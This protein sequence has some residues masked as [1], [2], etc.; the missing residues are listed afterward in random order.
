MSLRIVFMGTPDYGV[1]SLEALLQ[2]G[3]DVVGVF[4]QP[5][6]PSGRGKKITCCPVKQYAGCRDIPVFQPVKTRV[7]GVEPLRALA[8]DLCVTA[9]FGHILSQEVLDIPRIGTVNVHASLLP[10][11]RG[12]APVNWALINGE[13]VT[14]VTTMMTDKG[15]DTGDILLQREVNVLPG[16]NAGQL[17]ERLSKVGAELLIETIRAIER[18]D[19]PRRKQ[20]E[21]QA[22]YYP[23]L[24]KEMGKI[25]FG[26]T[27]KQLSDFV[28]GMT[29]WPG[30]Y[31][32]P[33]KVLEAVPEA[34]DGPERPGVILRADPKR[35]LLV[36]CGEGALN[37][38]RIQAAGGKPMNACDYLRGHQMEA[39]TLIAPENTDAE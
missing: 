27:A 7:D 35:G 32:G 3:Y 33:C 30:A 39:G 12:S 20:D 25:D 6:K 10:K 2:A 24:K 36:R 29:P 21:S 31:A 14:G 38:V 9:A 37:L 34:Y 18:G 26:R 28:R 11:Y 4:C 19:C 5:D 16:E 22:S 23:L 1:P 13:T 8:P 15:M 17:V